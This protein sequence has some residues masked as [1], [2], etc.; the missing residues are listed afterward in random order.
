MK[1][2]IQTASEVKN[3]SRTCTLAHETRKNRQGLA[4]FILVLF[5]VVSLG[6]GLASCG[7]SATAQPGGSSS[8]VRWEYKV[9]S[10][11]SIRALSTGHDLEQG[12][13]SLGNDGWEFIGT[14][15]GWS[16]E[17]IFK[18]RLQ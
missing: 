9:I 17:F 7:Q 3:S 10:G 18:R 13:N 14:P 11:Q 5:V 2:Q 15:S 4:V 16:S 6:L 12:L 1:N 8:N